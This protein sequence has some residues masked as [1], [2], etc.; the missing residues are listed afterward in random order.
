MPTTEEI[1]KSAGLTEEQIKAL[2]PKA[3]TAFSGMMTQAES[4]L[5]AA[6]E[7]RRKVEDWWAKEGQE[8]INGVY[9]KLTESQAREAYYRAQAEKAKEFGFIPTEAP[10]AAPAAPAAPPAA[11]P[12][13]PRA[14]DGRFQANS[15]PVPGSP[16]FMTKDEGY[17]ALANSAWYISEWARLHDGKMPDK[18]LEEMASEASSDR[19]KF[20]DH[21]ENKYFAPRRKEMAE[22]QQKERDD[23]LVADT[24]AAVEKEYAQ[25][26]GSNPDLRQGQ[27]SRFSR[28][29]EGQNGSKP[30]YPG[31]LNDRARKEQTRT[32]IHE[33]ASRDKATVH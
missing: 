20:R 21:V 14:A 15:N 4:N 28:Y 1:L 27:V 22:K 33:I 25:K 24:R 11:N 32:M 7:E 16:Q 2:D 6:K 29:T 17:Q 31:A 30:V 9:N 23:K 8:E 18:S 13:P 26:F 10:G 3:V 5:A 19:R 12:E